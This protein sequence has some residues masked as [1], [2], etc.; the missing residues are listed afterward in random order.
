MV[1]NRPFVTLS[2]AQSLD[3]SIAFRQGNSFPISS[4]ESLVLTHQL[5]ANH[6]AILV[7]I[8]TVLAD[9]PRLTVRHTSGKNPQ[10][11]IL[12]SQLR[13][14]PSAKLMASAPWI[15][16]TIS[17][18]VTRQAELERQGA[19]VERFSAEAGRVSLQQLLQWLCQQGINS[20]M[21]EGG[22]SVITAFLAQ[23]L[24]DQLIITVAPILLG[25]VT[26]ISSLPTPVPLHDMTIQPCGKDW[27]IRGLTMNKTAFTNF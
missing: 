22:S 23:Q 6:D 10:P 16:T 15:A 24:V 7:G 2:Y 13:F 17:A 20:L 18:D 4:H 27:I 25:G 12:D 26:A 21:V 5:R 14:P 8:G 1:K 3:G 9:D 19:H 11:I